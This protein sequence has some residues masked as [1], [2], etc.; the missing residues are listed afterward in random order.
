MEDSTQQTQIPTA[1]EVLDS[2][3]E[4]SDLISEESNLEIEKRNAIKIIEFAQLHC[5][6]QKEAIIEQVRLY[7]E[8][9]L[10]YNLKGNFCNP[11]QSITEKNMEEYHGNEGY[12]EDH[13]IV[14]VD[15]ESILNAYPDNLIK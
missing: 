7:K 13:I 15:K 3:E 1:I 14:R 11:Y 6:A 12:N 9:T 8:E 5:K 10:T 4:Y 2:L